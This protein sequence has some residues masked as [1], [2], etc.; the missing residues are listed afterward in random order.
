[1]STSHVVVF[2]ARANRTAI[3]VNPAKHLSDVLA[4]ACL[5]LK[6]DASLFGLR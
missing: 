3:K 6:A 2:D 5:K 4:E 1:M